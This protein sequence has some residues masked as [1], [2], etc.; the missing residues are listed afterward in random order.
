MGTPSRTAAVLARCT[1]FA[2][3]CLPALV[4]AQDTARMEELIR[5]RV[6]DG[7][8]TGA[9][10]VARGDE[11]IL[12]K[13]YGLA[14]RE[15]SI[16]NSP[17]TKF[18]L[19]SITKQFTAAAILKLADQGKLGIDDP[20]KKHWPAAP[21]AWDAVT[22]RHALTHTS[23]IPNFT[24]FPEFRTWQL[25]E[26]TPEKTVG[27]FRDKPLDFAPGARMS[28]S[29]SGYVLLAYLI[30]RVSGQ[31]YAEY[32][33]ANVL[34]PLGMKSSGYDLAATI[35]ESRAAG[36]TPTA[37]GVRNA[38]YVD[39][40]LPSGAGGLYSTTEDLLEWTQGLFGGRLLSAASLEAMTTPM[41]DNYAF[42]VVVGNAG[43][44]KTVEHNG[45]I[46]GFNTHLT[47]YPESKV[48]VAVLANLNGNAPGQLAAQLGRLAHGEAVVLSSERTTIELP[49]E[50]L[51]R[52]AGSY[53]LMP[54]ANM[55]ITV[56]GTQLMSRLGP[57]PAVPL[58]A[59]SE[60]K[61]FPRVV[62][63]ELE[64]E[65]DSSGN[66][67]AL[68]LRQGGRE[69]RGTRIEQRTEVA[70]PLAVLERYPGTYELA[71]GRE[72]VVTLENG[73]LMSQAT[74]QA[75]A[76]LF[77][78]AEDQFFLKAANAQIEFVRDGA[79]VT[80]LVLHQGGGETRA[81]RK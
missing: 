60:T 65:L 19:G 54:T 16:P 68:V 27:Y 56:E 77:A 67:T 81:K 71:P 36:Y 38:A 79:R 6:D 76:V 62:E 7:T 37:Q 13:G 75:K 10:L 3:V 9:V 64:F 45:G 66:A 55:V 39:M 70:L 33:R 49:R 21:A 35:I 80:E 44:R 23:G 63:A 30:E 31:S 4:A 29:N 5:A 2:V 51:D 18:R 32:L 34:E 61:F 41:L 8:F 43:G 42:G 1:A 25:T 50:K 28:Y 52:L 59:E 40:T 47:Y 22:I 73:Q 14:N 24:S 69:M 46:E 78:E 11:I 53:E 72:L 15:W 17:S 48:T 12:S 57:Q 20:V 58:F 26:T 74:G